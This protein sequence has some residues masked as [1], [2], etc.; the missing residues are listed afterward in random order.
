MGNQELQ[1]DTTIQVCILYRSVSCC[2]TLPSADINWIG[3][4]LLLFIPASASALTLAEQDGRCDVG[5]I[6][7]RR[8]RCVYTP[9]GEGEVET[10]RGKA[11]R[12]ELRGSLSP[13]LP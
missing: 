8:H 6:L 4:L 12:G 5:C 11:A 13:S 10:L 1:K 7:P 3:L 9:G 2:G